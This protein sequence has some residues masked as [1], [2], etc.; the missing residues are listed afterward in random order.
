MRILLIGAPGAGKG[1]QAEKLAN[2]FKIPRLTTGDLLRQAI[3]EETPLGKKV[4]AILER[5]S[6]VSDPTIL[7]LMEE[8]MA[9]PDAENGFI[10]DGFPRTVG[11]AEGLEKWLDEKNW[12][13]D[14]VIALNVSDSVAVERITGRRQCRKCG[15]AYHLRFNPPKEEGVC[16]SCG[17]S[18]TS[19]R[20]DEEATVRHRLK[21]YTKE[22]SPLVV[23]YEKKGLLR[24]LDGSRSPD[25]IFDDICSLIK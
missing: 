21:V 3:Q 9:K 17:S 15:A 12:N 1:T 24:R 7:E 19:R 25:Q 20:D 11:Q 18:L 14:H 16:D 5:G 22:T 10:L 4:E 6:L 8:R 23:F 13:L 2:F